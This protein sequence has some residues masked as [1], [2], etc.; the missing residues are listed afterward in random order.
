MPKLRSSGVLVIYLP[1]RWN[2]LSSWALDN[3]D[4]DLRNF[5]SRRGLAVAS[6]AYGTTALQAD[7]EA[8]AA[9]STGDL[10]IAVNSCFA[11]ADRA[12]GGGSVPVLVGYSLGAA[13]ACLAANGI[14]A[15]SVVLIDGG[16]EP[17]RKPA[18]G[19]DS[20]AMGPLVRSPSFDPRFRRMATAALNGEMPTAYFPGAD[21]DKLRYLLRASDEYWPAA[22]IAEVRRMGIDGTAGAALASIRQRLLIISRT[23]SGGRTP[24]ALEVPRWTS[25]QD[26]RVT[27]REGWSHS[28]MI[29]GSESPGLWREVA[30]WFD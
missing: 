18:L 12:L 1:G 16:L 7:H 9:L 2:N 3:P 22:Q 11:E 25:S 27:T 10:L 19:V 8:L 24:R 28:D 30:D 17:T 15:G 6:V 5:F 21:A 26:V 14:G 13:L 23:G 29:S 4:R 20:R